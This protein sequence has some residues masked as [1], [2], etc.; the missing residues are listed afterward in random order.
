M[1]KI[2]FKE[3]SFLLR[4]SQYLK[5][6]N[7]AAHIKKHSKTKGAAVA[8]RILYFALLD[9]SLNKQDGNDD[10]NWIIKPKS[11]A[12]ADATQDWMIEIGLEGLFEYFQKSTY[13]DALQSLKKSGLIF[14]D[15]RNSI[16]IKYPIN[17]NMLSPKFAFISILSQKKKAK[18]EKLPDSELD[19]DKDSEK[20]YNAESENVIGSGIKWD[21]M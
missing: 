10:A 14:V 12:L 7:L 13:K 21:E 19:I 5:D 15:K 16:H 6:V 4:Q 11:F 20:E 2:N 17:N 3:V 1:K 18:G 8:T 9:Q